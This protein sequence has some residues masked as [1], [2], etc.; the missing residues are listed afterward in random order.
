MA[1]GFYRNTLQIHAGTKICKTPQI[2]F[3]R[4]LRCQSGKFN[5]LFEP[6]PNG[7]GREQL[8]IL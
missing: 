2:S 1:V 8:Y 6:Q 7:D 4:F 3:L 5:S